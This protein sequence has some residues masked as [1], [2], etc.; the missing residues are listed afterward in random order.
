[1][2]RRAGRAARIARLEEE[3]RQS[4]RRY[5]RRLMA[6]ALLGY[7]L[8]LACVLLLLVLPL[9]LLLAVLAGAVDAAP[10]L[11]YLALPLLMGVGVLRALWFRF[12][13]PQGI[14]LADD[15]APALRAEVERLRARAGAPP[16][17]GILVDGQLNAGFASVPRVAGLLG[18]RHFLVLGWPLLQLVDRDELAAVIAHEFGHADAGASGF[19][20]WL[21]RMRASL[22]RAFDGD[23]DTA[24]DRFARHPNMIGSGYVLQRFLRWYVPYLEVLVHARGRGQ[25]LQADAAAVAA[26]SPA[27]AASASLRLALAQQRRDAR[28]DAALRTLA[29]E[30]S[31]PPAHPHAW[32]AAIDDRG[33]VAAPVRIIEASMGD[34]QAHDTHPSLARRLDAIGAAPV[35]APPGP[36][37]LALLGDAAERIERALDARWRDAMRAQWSGW[38]AAAVADGRRLEALEALPRH[39]VAEALE[40]ARLASSLRRGVDAVA[41]HRRVVDVADGSALAHLQL[42]EALVAAGDGA[43]AAKHFMDA[44]ARDAGALTTVAD[45][46]DARLGDPDLDAGV[47]AALLPLQATLA[48]RRRALAARTDT[49]TDNDADDDA[50]DDLAA[51][52]LDNDAVSSLRNALSRHPKVARAWVVQRR[53][54]MADAPLHFL[55]LVDWRGPVAGETAAMAR[56]QSSLTL[57]GPHAVLTGTNDAALVAR[58]RAVAGT[59]LYRR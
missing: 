59:P 27:V 46:V 38:H 4:P 19:E 11:V 45:A 14:A 36:A 10:G 40:H 48:P 17:A 18:H 3:A 54:A 5:A 49:G 37:A 56:L 53:A 28:L 58:L 23:G 20:A 47:V 51:H 32:M 6:I 35:L 57:P 42:A 29:R 44:I 30:Q 41:L 21:Q 52:G 39:D 55:L 22:L 16:L 34:V 8:L 31:H 26:T 13:P 50:D 12:T 1:M 2:D 24:A 25:E 33:T 7:G 43:G 9:V 15:E